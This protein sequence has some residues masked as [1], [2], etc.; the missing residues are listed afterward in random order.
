MNYLKL[1]EITHKINWIAFNIIF[2]VFKILSIHF[3]EYRRMEN[4]NYINKNIE[5]KN[6]NS[7]WKNQFSKVKNILLELEKYFIELKDT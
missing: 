6:L 2:F 4:P 3:R 5:R 7:M 1:R